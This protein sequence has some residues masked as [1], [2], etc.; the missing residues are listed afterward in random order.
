M[1]VTFTDRELDILKNLLNGLSNEE[2]GKILF[3]SKHT[4]K[5]N[6]E[7]IYLKTNCHNRVQ[8]AIW[9]LKNNIITPNQ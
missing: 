2:I 1:N 8:L 3:I 7:K 9:T 5:A 6:L 4:V